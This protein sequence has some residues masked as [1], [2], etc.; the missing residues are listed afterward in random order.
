M[1]LVGPMN[2]SI[3][4]LIHQFCD[5][6]EH[7]RHDPSEFGEEEYQIFSRLLLKLLDVA[8]LIKSYPSSKRSSPSKTPIKKTGTCDSKRIENIAKGTDREG[9]P[10]TLILPVNTSILKSLESTVI[11]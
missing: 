9:R 1:T 2:G 6:Y 7:A 5:L 10:Q 8:K 11:P 4:K 3:Q